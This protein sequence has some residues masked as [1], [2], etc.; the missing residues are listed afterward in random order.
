MSK[1]LADARVVADE[2]LAVEAISFCYLVTSSPIYFLW[3]ACT[4]A[5]SGGVVTVSASHQAGCSMM[6]RRGKCCPDVMCTPT[7]ALDAVL[8]EHHALGG[9]GAADL[10][11]AVISACQQKIDF[12]FLYEVTQSIKVGLLW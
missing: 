7:G 11:N 10:G 5:L 2:A 3:L 6:H 8:C 9:A 1:Q 12:K 4:A